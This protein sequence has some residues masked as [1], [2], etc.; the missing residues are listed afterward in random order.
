MPDAYP[1][2]FG[3]VLALVMSSLVPAQAQDEK[4]AVLAVVKQLFDGMRPERV[5]MV[6]GA[7][8]P[9]AQLFSS[10]TKEGAAEVA[11]TL[12]LHGGGHPSATGG[13]R[14]ADGARSMQSDGAFAAVWADY[15]LLPLMPTFSH[16]GV[17]AFHLAKNA[18]GWKIVALGDTR[19]TGGWRVAEVTDALGRRLNRATRSGRSTR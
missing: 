5:P 8:H 17:D 7:F 19:R 4:A 18:G 11:V 2:L 14:R 1:R 12:G 13:E 9:S 3:V 16:C 6:E 15:A 10:S